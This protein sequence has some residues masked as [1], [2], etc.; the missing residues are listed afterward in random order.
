M[1]SLS[2]DDIAV[3]ITQ[4]YS[5]WNWSYAHVYKKSQEC[6]GVNKVVVFW[7]SVA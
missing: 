4:E 3:Q 5:I 6:G 1:D 7:R 2:I